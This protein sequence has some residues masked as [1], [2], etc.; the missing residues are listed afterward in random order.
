MFYMEFQILEIPVFYIKIWKNE[1]RNDKKKIKIL[2]RREEVHPQEVHPKRLYDMGDFTHTKVYGK[3]PSGPKRKFRDRSLL[4]MLSG[5]GAADKVLK[6]KALDRREKNRKQDGKRGAAEAGLEHD[7][8]V[9]ALRQKQMEDHAR[10]KA[11]CN[12]LSPM[13][14]HPIG[15]LKKAGSVQRLRCFSTKCL[16]KK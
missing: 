14:L 3:L 16:P 6:A 1:W 12:N 2:N 10:R 5:V 7:P 11:E 8:E 9:Q 13:A 4:T 15:G